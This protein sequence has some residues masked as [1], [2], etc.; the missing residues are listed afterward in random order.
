MEDHHS[1]KGYY[2]KIQSDAREYLTYN[3][4]AV[5]VELIH[6][7]KDEFPLSFSLPI[8][9]EGKDFQLILSLPSTFPDV[10]PKVSLDEESFKKIFPIPHLSM[11][12]DLCVFD[13]VQAS[14]NPEHPIGVLDITI[15]KSLEIL[16]QGLAGEN[17]GDYT[18]EFHTYWVQES[19]EELL[20][21]VSSSTIPKEVF[22]IPFNKKGWFYKRIFADSN[23]DA[24]KWLQNSGANI[25]DENVLSALYIPLT[26]PLEYPFPQKNKDI[27]NLVKKEPETL[28]ALTNFLSKNKR[29][30]YVLFS[31]NVADDY[32]WGAWT[33]N[34]PSKT[35][36]LKY[37]GRKRTR[38]T[39]KGFR[40]NLTNPILE[41]VRDFSNVSIDK[42]SIE[43]VHKERLV[44]RGGD[45]SLEYHDSKVAVIGCGSVG[46]HLVQALVDIKVS[47]IL[48][49]DSDRLT[50]ENIN[51][52]L[53]GAS[54][55]LVPKVQAVKDKIRRHDPSLMVH[56]T[57]SDVL[58][59]LKNYPNALNDF[60]FNIVAIANFPVE[61]RLNRMQ[62]H[63]EITKPVLY[64]WVEPYLAGGHAVWID[65]RDKGCLRCLFDKGGQYRHE[66]L[67]NGNLFTKRELGCNTSY[68]PYG[69]L[70]LKRFILDLMF[71]IQEQLG[72]N[73]RE[74]R[75][76]TWLGDLEQQRA[77]GRVLK[78]KWIAAKSYSIRNSQL[79][80]QHGCVHSHDL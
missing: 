27:Y 19:K 36:V 73:Q 25:D 72:D 32:A 44:V 31:V 77:S 13:S 51:R 54:E 12:N 1:L 38:N 57:D 62:H 46:S 14:P 68:V 64:V 37:K 4:G 35:E 47:E 8:K 7:K 30:S 69:V 80:K 67:M 9:V 29:P 48:L 20:S 55:V 26:K 59:F 21:I 5:E 6:F 2:Q 18:D 11:A 28:K 22:I 56:S 66:I 58:K 33:H 63:D 16:K 74:S 76:F 61:I 23:I 71:F 17:H 53:C 40:Q 78:P 10:F 65:P 70:E 42:Y 60:D 79:I 39:L 3:Y 52:H 34:I 24:I 15:Q 41:L 43:N 49:V 50:F 75:V 45:G